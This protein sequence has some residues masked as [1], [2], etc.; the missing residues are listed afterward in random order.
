MLRVGSKQVVSAVGR[1]VGFDKLAYVLI[2]LPGSLRTL[3]T[4]LSKV[5]MSG[6]AD[7]LELRLNSAAPKSIY[8][9]G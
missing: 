2:P 3:Q 5:G 8:F 9:M 7:D 6:L 4:M 1:L